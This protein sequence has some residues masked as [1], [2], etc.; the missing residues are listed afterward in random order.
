MNSLPSRKGRDEGEHS[1]K[2]KTLY[3]GLEADEN[4]PERQART[5]LPYPHFT[6]EELKPREPHRKKNQDKNSDF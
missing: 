5:Y 4:N 1:S 2:G 3:K 6:D